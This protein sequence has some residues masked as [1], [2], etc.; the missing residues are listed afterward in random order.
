[1]CEET[2]KRY[3]GG[4]KRGG[5]TKVRIKYIYNARTMNVCVYGKKVPGVKSSAKI[6]AASVPIV[7]NFCDGHIIRY[8]AAQ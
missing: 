6:A 1:M 4:G 8:A 2:I 5:A 7:K 3:Q